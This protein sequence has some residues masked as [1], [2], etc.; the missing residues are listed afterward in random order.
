MLNI[1]LGYNANI[2]DKCK[3]LKEYA[4]FIALV[5]EYLEQ[6]YGIAEAVDMAMNT[7]IQA[8]ILEEIL[9]NHREEV[10]AML[11][12]EYDEQAHIKNEREIALEEG[13]ARLTKLLQ[14]LLDAGRNDE[15]NRAICDVEFRKKLYQEYKI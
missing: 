3:K 8:G 6:G 1:N 4:Q 15:L 12:T 2:L 9:R 10:R 14:A 7:S 13:E 11:L 5:R